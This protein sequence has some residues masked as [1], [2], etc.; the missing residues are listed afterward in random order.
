[1][2]SYYVELALRSFRRNPGLTALMALAI[3]FGVAAAMTTFSVFRAVSGDPIPWKSSRLFIPQVDTSGPAERGKGGEPPRAMDYATASALMGDHRGALQSAIYKISPVV[4]ATDAGS[5]PVNVDGHAV[6]SEFFPMLDVP[7]RY[8][9]GWNRQDDEQ[10][11]NV[12]VIGEKLNRQLFHDGNSIGKTLNIEERSYRIVGVM[13]H[14]DPQPRFFDVVNTGGFSTA[15]EDLLL[16]FHTAIDAGIATT[17]NTVCSKSPSAPGVAGLKNSTC[18]WIAY[19]VQLDGKEAA[20]TFL[21]YL[22]RYARQL[23]DSGAVQWDPNNRLR[24]LP[25][26]LDAQHVVPADTGLSLLVALGL[27]IVC[28][29]NTSGLLLAKFFRRSGEIGL[30]RALGASRGAIYAQFLIETGVIGLIGGCLGLALTVFG[31][32]CVQW[33]LPSDIASLAHVDPV[34]LV[35]TL[36]LAL[37]S[38]LLAGLYPTF[39]ATLVQLTWQLK[40]N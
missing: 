3:G 22:D 36:S 40:S 24:N 30:R 2:F 12:V 27:L 39:R 21:R 5:H 10:R 29:V 6:S 20:D 4:T 9:S 25:A 19:M 13:S 26:W 23:K 34:L 14:W 31:V 35:L 37:A 32:M 18:T 28:L 11:A 1:M 17:G 16:P 15:S 8:G 33:L 7:F 38:T